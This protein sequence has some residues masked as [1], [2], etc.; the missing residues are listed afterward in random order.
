MRAYICLSIAAENIRE[1]INIAQETEK[2]IDLFEIRLDYLENKNEI[3]DVRLPCRTIYTFRP[4]RQ[5]GLFAGNENDR[6]NLLIKI[7]RTFPNSFIDLEYD[8]P[9]EIFYEINKSCSTICSY[10]EFTEEWN[11]ND[12][13]KALDK[14]AE[15]FKIA[16]MA[17]STEKI[18][19]CIDILHSLRNQGK[20]LNL[21][22]MGSQGQWFRIVAS[23]L[24]LPWTYICYSPQLQTAPGQLSFNQ[25][26]KIYRLNEVDMSYSVFGIIGKPLSHSISPVIHN[27]AFKE[28]SCKAIYAPFEIDNVELFINKINK[29]I[30][31]RG[32]SIT[33]PFKQSILSLID[34]VD[35]NAIKIG[36]VNTLKYKESK[37]I[38]FNTDW[39]GF[40]N[41][42]LKVCNPANRKA[43][44]LGAGGAASAIVYALKK[45]GAKVAISNRSNIKALEFAKRFYIDFVLWDERHNYNYDILINATPI[46]MYPNINSKPI[47][48]ESID[49]KIIYDLIYNPLET[50]LL[51]EANLKG[52]IVI[53]GLEMLIE[54]AVEQIKIWTGRFPP[55]NMIREVAN[56]YLQDIF[57]CLF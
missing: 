28:L 2:F 50:E 38:G 5:G 9:N 7:A 17:N 4:K 49:G 41:P 3:F 37:W 19:R 54:Q 55:K 27:I 44:V 26:I 21:V 20:N 13:V 1:L 6:L 46:G 8:V 52:A 34:Q 57:S 31:L 35:E 56:A 32:L 24:K 25:A 12:I 30:P 18:F 42:L 40:I 10:H 16:L 39:I 22:V 43:L 47:K 51:K 14:P 36:A 23:F 29:I 45:L 11:M 48:L 33:I 15:M 53:N